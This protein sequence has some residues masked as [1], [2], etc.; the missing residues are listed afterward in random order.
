MKQ[1]KDYVEEVVKV[2]GEM[3]GNQKI[4]SADKLANIMNKHYVL[5]IPNNDE[6]IGYEEAISTAIAYNL[7][8]FVGLQRMVAV[9]FRGVFTNDELGCIFQALNGVIPTVE[10]PEWAMH[11]VVDFA[12]HEGAVVYGVGDK[13]FNKLA[14][15][16]P[17]EFSILASVIVEAWD[18][19]RMEISPEVRAQHPEVTDVIGM[20]HKYLSKEMVDSED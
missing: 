15:A 18:T 17:V 8:V 19:N 10:N 1:K 14:D 4:Y 9:R 5:P 13:F 3:T 7:D 16:N 6:A 2:A 12:K 11:N 20:L